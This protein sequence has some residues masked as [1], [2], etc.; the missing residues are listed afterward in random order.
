MNL[1]HRS[2]ALKGHIAAL[3]QSTAFVPAPPSPPHNSKSHAHSSLYDEEKHE[4]PS[5][6]HFAPASPLHNA[7]QAAHAQALYS[8]SASPSPPPHAHPHSARVPKR[9]SSHD[10]ADGGPA[11][12]AT[13]VIP[14]HYN[15]NH[16]NRAANS[17]PIAL[18][19][20]HH[21]NNSGAMVP[22]TASPPAAS[23]W[24]LPPAANSK[25]NPNLPPS[26][27][28]LYVAVPYPSPNGGWAY[29]LYDPATASGS[30]PVAN[31]AFLPQLATPHSATQS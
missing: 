17:S 2:S 14:N 1:G 25:V 19:P 22:S 9:Y 21:T 20:T 30:P 6:Y 18:L 27:Q 24:A 23:W 15:S 13:F 7:S 31:A 26:Q 29:S 10:S 16:S 28:Q 5:P 3:K 8:P 4:L 12:P 11:S